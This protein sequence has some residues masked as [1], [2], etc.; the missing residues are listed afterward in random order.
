MAT[1]TQAEI[2]NNLDRWFGLKFAAYPPAMLTA[3]AV[4]I[5]MKPDDRKRTL[6]AC[7]AFFCPHCGDTQSMD[8]PR[9]QCWNDE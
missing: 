1:M 4:L 8:Q 9:C 6:D 5:N 2:K 3:L 7:G